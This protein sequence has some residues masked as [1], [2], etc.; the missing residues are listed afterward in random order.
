MS[1]LA[2]TWNTHRHRLMQRDQLLLT[3]VLML[4]ASFLLLLS[5]VSASTQRH[6]EKN[7]QSMLGSDMV[8]SQFQALSPSQEQ[9]LRTR[10]DA[11]SRTRLLDI[12]LSNGERWEPVQLKLVDSHYPIQGRLSIAEVP[13]GDTASVPVGP[14]EGELWVGSRLLSRLGLRVGQ[15][16]N[17]GA[18]TLRISAILHH[19][20]DRLLEGH[21]VK[22]RALAHE[23][24]LAS[25][26]P[27]VGRLAVSLSDRCRGATSAYHP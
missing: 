1:L 7:L 17:V 11:V 18:A 8:L 2:L 24:T 9:A 22:L 15:N 19:E 20:P 21:S 13:G 23:N 6:L 10:A 5:M 14:R 3:G 27:R 26:G 12:N 25:S 16:V 4:L